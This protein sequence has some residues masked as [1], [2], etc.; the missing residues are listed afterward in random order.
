MSTI[1][2]LLVI[3]WLLHV[4]LWGF[5]TKAQKPGWHT[6]VP[7]L[8]DMTLLEICGKKK[9]LAVF[10]LVPFINFFVAILW[11]A[12]MLNSF[13]K[14]SFIEHTQGLLLGLFYLPFWG[15]SKSVL[16]EGPSGILDRQKRIVK[17]PG[18]E[19][20]D[21]IIYA[22]FAAALIRMFM[23][24]AYK[25]PSS[26]MEGTL[27]TGDFLFVSKFHYGPRIPNTPLAFPFAH[28]T[29][30]VLKTKAYSEAIKLKYR[31]VP[32]LQK[33]K[34]FDSVVFNYP[35]GDTVSQQW[36]SNISYYQLLRY[37][38]Q[39]I[40]NRYKDLSDAEY[41]K[42]ARESVAK[43]N[44]LVVRPVD[45]K[46]NFIKR[47][48]GIPGDKLELKMGELYVNDQLAW[49]PKQLYIKTKVN[50]ASSL[51]P[52]SKA[53]KDNN[54]GQNQMNGNGI[55]FLNPTQIEGLKKNPAIESV[56]PI[57]EYA[58]EIN[59]NFWQN[60]FVGGNVDNFDA[61]IIP[62]KGWTVKLDASNI[63]RYKRAIQVYEKND[64]QIDAN[65]GITINGVKTNEYTFKMDYYFMM[66]D[67]RH[68][69]VDS[70]F[71]GFVPEDHIVG[72]PLFVWLSI[73]PPYWDGPQNNVPNKNGLLKKIR[74][75][76]LFKS[77]HGKYINGDI[78]RD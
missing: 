13:G 57:V 73:E 3:Y 53:I 21:A 17:S 41:K 29:M 48:V 5:Y 66:G 24:E 38:E 31:R 55:F 64:L 68:N 51:T 63:N 19:W 23:L 65:G 11:V 71:W 39:N 15:A 47:C 58:S 78:P 75:D 8:Q 26:S 2:V 6:L 33:I 42:M 25:I 45:K 30:P 54:I 44:T 43:Q 74:F 14:R 10:S 18:R 1:I 60:E 67:N 61:F 70:R 9:W 28:H 34:R 32:G 49:K 12:E 69:S 77:V 27:L 76:R 22:F 56:E 7:I 37:E 36:Q 4:L 20:A 16:Y 72:K 46:E 35:E 62:K 52:G 40:R 50:S 59:Q